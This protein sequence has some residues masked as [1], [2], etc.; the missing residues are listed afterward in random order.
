M[1]A[2]TFAAD[3]ATTE[4]KLQIIEESF[5]AGETVSSTARIGR[6]EKLTAPLFP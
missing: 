1:I 4:Q 3:G 6:N 2:G 5:E